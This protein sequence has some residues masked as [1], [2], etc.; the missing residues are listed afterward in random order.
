M[1]IAV[2]QVKQIYKMDESAL[3]ALLTE[4]KHKLGEQI[5][6]I[7]QSLKKIE[8]KQR[9]LERIMQL[10]SQPLCVEYKQ[11]PAIY[12]VDLYQAE[13]VKQSITPFQSA[14]LF[15]PEKPEDCQ[16]GMF[17]P[18]KTGKLLRPADSEARLYLTGLLTWNH[19]SNQHNLVQL[20][21]ECKAMG[22]RPCYAVSNFLAFAADSR[23]GTQDYAEVWIAAEQENQD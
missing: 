11:L 18:N 15:L 21:D 17:L 16:F 9:A 2:E 19:Y 14:D 3:L 4:N 22:Y 7:K 5:K 8:L 23:R 6:Q 20:F 10:K 1:D 12:A 13:D